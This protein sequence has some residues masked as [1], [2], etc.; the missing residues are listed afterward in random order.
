[1]SKIIDTVYASTISFDSQAKGVNIKDLTRSIHAFLPTA[2]IVF[3]SNRTEIV[4]IDDGLSVTI[5]LDFSQDTINVHGFVAEEDAEVVDEIAH[6]ICDLSDG[7]FEESNYAPV[8]Y[9]I[10]YGYEDGEDDDE[11]EAELPPGAQLAGPLTNI[12]CG[13]CT[14]CAD[15]AADMEAEQAPLRAK[16]YFKDFGAP[17]DAM[18]ER[19][20]K[21]NPELKRGPQV[22]D[23]PFGK[24]VLISLSDVEDQFGINATN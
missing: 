23:T 13:D 4:A 15:L 8:S 14:V 16:G 20:R 24:A 1:M 2:S 9:V 22:I 17:N 12:G 3:S 19:I 11:F 10:D 18:L 5:Q 21:D 7:I 6:M